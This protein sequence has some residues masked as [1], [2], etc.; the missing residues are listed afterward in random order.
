M[1]EKQTQM[2]SVIKVVHLWKKNLDKGGKY[3]QI[4]EKTLANVPTL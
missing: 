3:A 1:F 2:F 4:Y